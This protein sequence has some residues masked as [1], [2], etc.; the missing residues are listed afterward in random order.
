MGTVEQGWL[1]GSSREAPDWE[2]TQN[3]FAHVTGSV[4]S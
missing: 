4:S 2:K 1:V 3:G